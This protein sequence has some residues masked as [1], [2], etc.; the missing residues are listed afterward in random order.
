MK[1]ILLILFVAVIQLLTL[2]LLPVLL[3]VILVL[4]KLNKFDQLMAELMEYKPPYC[5][6]VYKKD[7]N[8][9][10]AL[11]EPY[12]TIW[13]TGTLPNKMVLG[14]YNSA[15]G[16]IY[17]KRV[18]V[19][20]EAQKAKV[21][22]TYFHELR[23]RKQHMTMPDKLYSSKAKM[24]FGHVSYYDSWHER[25]ARKAGRRMSKIFMRRSL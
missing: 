17:I 20:T 18:L 7:S 8:F 6:V 5:E 21:A 12:L 15:S 14:S 9:I 3:P 11:L 25:D 22:D 13:V 23:H 10:V 19:I 24:V 4:K 1:K 16:T 2:V